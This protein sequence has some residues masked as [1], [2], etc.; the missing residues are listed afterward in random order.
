MGMPR[1][2][3]IAAAQYDLPQR[4]AWFNS[5]IA[6]LGGVI[7]FVSGVLYLVVIA[8]TLTVSRQPAEVEVP[9]AE[10]AP[11]ERRVPALLD[12]WRP[13]VVFA[14]TLTLIAWVPPLVMVIGT[15]S[16]VR[17]VRVW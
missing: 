10:Y 14:I 17:G 16:P 12:R 9:L 5:P 15:L 11:G 1:R 7:L 6:A 13:W 2:T 3:Q 4:H 8:L